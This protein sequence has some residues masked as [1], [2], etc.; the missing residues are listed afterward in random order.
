[1]SYSFSD[2]IQILSSFLWDLFENYLEKF[3]NNFYARDDFHVSGRFRYTVGS[4]GGDGA[5]NFAELDSDFS[6][7]GKHV[8]NI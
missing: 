2:N 7:P 6:E 8:L 3:W 1:M 4:G 5:A